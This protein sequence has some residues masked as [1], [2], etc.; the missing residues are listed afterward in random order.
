MF[1]VFDRPNLFFLDRAFNARGTQDP[2]PAVTIVA[3]SQEDFER[4]APRWP[5]PRSLMARLV[6]EIAEQKPAVI[7]MDILYSENTNSET[8]ITRDRFKESQPYLYQVLAGVKL[9]VRNQ[10]GVRVIGPGSPAFDEAAL[11]TASA[12]AQDQELANAVARALDN[13]V[14]VVLSAQTV[15]GIGTNGLARP[16]PSLAQSINND[17]RG[18]LGLVGVRMDQD[19]VLRRYL[20]YGV[21]QNGDFIYGL[22]LNVV[23]QYQGV[24]LPETPVPG[25][26]VL[27]GGLETV[28][29]KD[30]EFLVNYPG[31]PGTHPAIPA[32][33]I[34]RG[35]KEYAD[36]LAGK[37]VFI[38][39]TDPSAV[40]MVPTPFSGTDRMAGVEFHAAAADTILKGSYITQPPGYQVVLMVL[41]L[42]ASAVALGRFVRPVFGMAGGLALAGGIFAGWW[43]G[44]SG[45]NY[46]LPIAGPLAALAAGYAVAIAD[47]V[48]VEQLE[49]QQARSML[50][51]YLP[52]GLVSEMV[53]NP[54]AAQLGVKRAEVT[55]LFA[56]IRGF[57]T[58]S[59]K[60]PPEEVVVLL[61]EY[62][63]TMTDVIFRHEGTIDKFEGDAILFFFGAPQVHQDDPERA[64]RCALEMR[65]QL[66]GLDDS[67]RQQTK[68]GLE[69]GIGIN[70]GPAMVGNIGSQRR[71][72]YTV[73]GDTVN[74]A[75]RLQDLTK[76]HGAPIL[77]SGAVQNRVNNIAQTRFIGAVQVRGREQSVDVYE[78]TGQNP[79]GQNPVT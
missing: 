18:S 68:A 59:E 69:I 12:K 43:G 71:M 2:D 31:P 29:V 51:R 9:E 73:I 1:G 24:E 58:F 52:S 64:V 54:Q 75:S 76:E 72:D 25:G 50:S 11:G 40:D 47:R 23:A 26:N 38:G 35:G 48:G 60:M 15:F 16:Y 5:W 44:F 21:D 37:I 70:T 78:V 3:I 62:L 10:D 66:A 46:A 49:K 22:A 34:F 77:V 45:A 74:L 32:G 67:W 61:N 56:D 36:D 13:G 42:G 17:S 39:V 28:Q 53:K 79:N 27:I 30:W 20:P 8:L 7:A 65:D 57:T 63:T 41:F 4:G 14:S 6:D 55:V 33:N 19:G